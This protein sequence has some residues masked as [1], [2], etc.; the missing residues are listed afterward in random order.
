M[1]RG[2]A[3]PESPSAPGWYPDPW[4]ATGTGERYF[5]GKRWGTTEKPRGRHSAPVLT[6]IAERSSARAGRGRTFVSIAVVVA[7]VAAVWYLQRPGGSDAGS[8]RSQ[9]ANQPPAGAEE[10][11]HRLVA[12]VPPPAGTGDYQFIAHQTNDATKPVGFDPCR[13]VHYVVNLTGAPADALPLVQ[14]AVATVAANTGLKFVYDGQTTE[15]PDHQRA[16]YQPETYG[17]KRWAPVLIAWSDETAT[18]DLAGYIL[19]VGGAESVTPPG[20]PSVYVTGQVVLDREELSTTAMPDRG[21][22]RAVVLHE[23]GHVVGLAHVADPTQ[24]MY[25]ESQF[26]VREYGAGDLRGLARVGSGACVPRV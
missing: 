4:S 26:G 25:S 22:A 23:L 21:L 14:N 12:A 20:G 17:T 13:P 10:S 1:G 11:A 24:L 3:T 8:G 16:A 18:P 15:L 2:D 7:L 9:A 5:D 19:G 6:D